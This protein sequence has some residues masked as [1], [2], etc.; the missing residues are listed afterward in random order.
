[1]ADQVKVHDLA[2]FGQFRVALLKFAQAA[3]LALTGAEAEISR[4]RSWLEGEQ[5]TFWESQHRKRMEAVTKAKD[6]VR[7]KKLYK[8]AT[9]RV[10]NAVEEEK[11]LAKCVAAVDEA[12]RKMEAVRKWVP[13]LEKEA[14]FYRG[15]VSRLN[16][17]IVDNVPRAVALLDRLAATL[18][19]YVAMEAPGAG[20]AEGAVEG[21][22]MGRGGEAVEDKSVKE[23]N[24]KGGEGESSLRGGGDPLGNVK[25]D[26]ANQEIGGPARLETGGV[27]APGARS[28]GGDAGATGKE[29]GDGSSGR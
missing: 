14:N 26:E 6:A 9:G 20:A 28:I 2:V 22:A 7:Q 10:R 16:Q 13:R 17:T 12:Q 21:G 18:E 29:G 11:V 24:I 19:E 25:R 3:D 1:M 27:H 23:K 4:T 5:R 15:G 8:D